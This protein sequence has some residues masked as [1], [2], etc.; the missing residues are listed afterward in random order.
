MAERVRSGPL[1]EAVPRFRK[2]DEGSGGS[3]EDYTTPTG[4]TTARRA[5]TR[6]LDE[7]LKRVMD[8]KIIE[9]EKEKEKYTPVQLTKEEL[10]A[11][12]VEDLNGI[13]PVVSFGS[14]CFAAFVS[15]LFW[16]ITIGLS[17][18]LN[19]VQV[20]EEPVVVVVVVVRIC[21]GGSSSKHM[22]RGQE[23]VFTCCSHALSLPSSE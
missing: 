15:F 7:R 14:A 5:R 12:Q 3:S 2:G 21:S 22:G 6:T 23:R 1:E 16:R 10:E 18:A 8:A 17:V 11:Q 20:R 9:I 19:G 13:N 4:A